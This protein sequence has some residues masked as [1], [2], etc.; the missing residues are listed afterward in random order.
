THERRIFVGSAAPFYLT[1]GTPKMAHFFNPK[2]SAR[3]PTSVF[4]V[5]VNR[6]IYVRLWNVGGPDLTVVA[7]DPSIVSVLFGTGRTSPAQ[8]E[9]GIYEFSLYGNKVGNCP[10]RAKNAQGN[11]WALTQAAVALPSGVSQYGP[12]YPTA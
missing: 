5:G 8:I 10:I 11:Q 6:N 2:D 4:N 3:T 9:D 12:V 1:K 7:D